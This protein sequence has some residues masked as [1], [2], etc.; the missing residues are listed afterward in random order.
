MTIE[1]GSDIMKDFFHD[2]LPKID[3]DLIGICNLSQWENTKLEE[4]ALRLLPETHS[5]VV[6]AMEIYT[7]VLDLSSPK[8]VMGAASTN[9]LLTQHM[10][11]LGGRLTRAA[12]DVAKASH[13]SGFQALPLPSAGCPT[14]SRFLEAVFSY[15]HAGQC[16]GIGKIGWH[17]L[18][19]A[20]QFGSRIRLS[21]CLTEAELEP[22]NLRNLVECN[23]CGK[24]VD[25]CP[26]KALLTPSKHEVYSINKFA[27]SAYR[28]AAGGC[29][30]CIRSCPLT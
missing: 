19:I 15:K 9:D 24:C 14:D 11:F 23:G 8:R 17:S 1:H 22:T 4:T 5:V 3:V 21:C 27:C 28:N 7:E 10:D 25:N 12:Y 2:S 30:E 6:F 16:A 13:K 20:P 26:A 29:S 18:L